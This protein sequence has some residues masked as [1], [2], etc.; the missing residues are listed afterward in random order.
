MGPAVL[1]QTFQRL[2]LPALCVDGEHG[3]GIDHFAVHD[4]GAG[5]AGAAIAYAFGGGDIQA[6]PQRIEQSAARLDAGAVGLAV[7]LERDGNFAGSGDLGGG[8]RVRFGF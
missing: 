6:V 8:L 2:D 5:A 4:Y 3:E 1:R 7:D